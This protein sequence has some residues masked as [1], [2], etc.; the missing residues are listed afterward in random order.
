MDNILDVSFLLHDAASDFFARHFFVIK[1]MLLILAHLSLFGF[2]FPG[3]RKDLGNISVFLLFVILFISP[4]SKIFR[5]RLLLQVMS[6][7]RELGIWMAYVATVHGVGYLLDPLWLSQNIVP[8][9]NASFFSIDTRYILGIAAYTLTL[10]LL[11][12]SNTLSIKF[13]G[14]KAWKRLHSMAY[15]LF[16]LVLFHFFL[17]T[18]R[19]DNFG[20]ISVL[21][22]FSGYIFL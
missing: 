20:I 14:P 5:M 1:R 15:P 22:V 7:R 13:F 21:A 9:W 19:A 2:L 12:T 18:G 3:I 10:P 17:R 16:L 11:F 8:Y 6:V 4:L